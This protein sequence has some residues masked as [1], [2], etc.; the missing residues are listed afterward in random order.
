MQETRVQSQS[1]IKRYVLAGKAIFTLLSTKL[2][3]RYTY[4]VFL[5]KDLTN[6][7]VKVLFGNDNSCDKMY[8][9]VCWFDPF[10][11]NI[12]FSRGLTSTPNRMF[13]YFIQCLFTD[14]PLPD[15]CEFYH[16]GKCARCGRLLTTPE[17]I[18]TGL[19]PICEKIMRG[20]NNDEV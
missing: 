13:L 6:Y 20:E 7:Q 16:S 12:V 14:T 17:S 11:K 4:K 2:D 1:D 10:T 8:R 18:K 19:G 15:T 9:H 3:K 5:Q